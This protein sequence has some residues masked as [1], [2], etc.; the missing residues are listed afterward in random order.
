MRILVIDDHV[1]LIANIFAIFEQ[2]NYIL[3]V[4]QDAFSALALC[5]N[6]HYDILILDWMLP[7]LSGIDFLK[8]IRSEY[9]YTPVIML[10]AKSDLEDKLAGFSVGAD[11]YLTKP[12]STRELRA[13]VKALHARSIGKNVILQISDLSYNTK[14]D[15]VIRNHIAIKLNPS[16]KKILALLM[17]ESPNIV[18]RERL[19]FAIWRD[20]PPN[21]DLLR[22]YIYELRRKLCLGTES[23]LIKTC[24]KLGYQILAEDSCHD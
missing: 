18:S 3:D 14:T 5:R 4:A 16:E 9:I 11:D 22:T 20:N 12:F 23:K 7:K 10:T 17:R 6:N 15:E 24:H 13:R 2:D 21:K 19:E 8:K 1:D